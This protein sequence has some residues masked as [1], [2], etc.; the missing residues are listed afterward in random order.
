MLTY[1]VNT[2][3][4]KKHKFAFYIGKVNGVII[5]KPGNKN[6]YYLGANLNCHT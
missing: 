2:S 4:I 1:S 5:I 3:Y 6:M